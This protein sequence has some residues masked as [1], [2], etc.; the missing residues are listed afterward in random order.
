MKKLI[1]FLKKLKD[2]VY[3]KLIEILV[4][5]ESRRMPKKLEEDFK[6]LKEQFSFYNDLNQIQKICMILGGI[7]IAIIVIYWHFAVITMI[8]RLF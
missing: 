8:F 7:I 6:E 3:I 4:E 2:K 5:S 1:S